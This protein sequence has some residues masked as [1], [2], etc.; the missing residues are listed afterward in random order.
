MWMMFIVCL[1]CETRRRDAIASV[2][3]S[4]VAVPYH[5]ILKL[6]RTEKDIFKLT[7]F[8]LLCF[9]FMNPRQDLLFT[10]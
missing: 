10:I 7:C 3:F 1:L 5:A 8:D 2:D 9:S 4:T 6:K